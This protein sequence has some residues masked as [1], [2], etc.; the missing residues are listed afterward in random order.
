[1]T[2]PDEGRL[3]PA[4]EQLPGTGRP[5]G[6]GPSERLARAGLTRVLEPGDSRGGQWLRRLGPVALFDR[7]RGEG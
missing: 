4:Q 1:M 3:P 2:P 7:L 6:D 5:S